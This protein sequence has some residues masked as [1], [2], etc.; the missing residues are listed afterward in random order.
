MISPINW[1]RSLEVRTNTMLEEISDRAHNVR[2]FKGL[3]ISRRR[4]KRKV[5]VQEKLPTIIIFFD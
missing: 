1:V 2:K 3:T 5:K 4:V